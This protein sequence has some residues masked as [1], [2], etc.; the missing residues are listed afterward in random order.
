MTPAQLGWVAGLID[1]KARAKVV[2]APSRGNR[3]IVSMYVESR[4]FAILE[5]LGRLTGQ[6]VHSRTPLKPIDW[7]RKGCSE[8]CPEPHVHVQKSMP[9][10]G[11]WAMT[12]VGAAIVLHN[13]KT[14]LV[15][16]RGFSEMAAMGLSGAPAPYSRGWAACERS[17][18]RLEALG[19][20]IPSALLIDVEDEEP[21][22]VG[23]GAGR[24]LR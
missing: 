13:V 7:D 23:S 1:M 16:D 10:V 22:E 21:E 18:R 19:W 12:G 14:M 20:Q 3:P 4:E 11:R 6:Q 15:T 24:V 5:R 8:H 17:I 9:P 2:V